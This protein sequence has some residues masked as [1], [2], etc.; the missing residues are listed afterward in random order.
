MKV[1]SNA[2]KKSASSNFK[3]YLEQKTIDTTNQYF[4]CIDTGILITALWQRTLKN[5]THFE[6]IF[7]KVR[8]FWD[9]INALL[10]FFLIRD[11]VNA[12]RIFFFKMRYGG[13]LTLFFIERLNA[14]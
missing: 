2:E 4:T 7:F 9:Q 6:E 11:Q 3:A 13:T 5:I 1:A 10:I 14:L 8:Q 12:I